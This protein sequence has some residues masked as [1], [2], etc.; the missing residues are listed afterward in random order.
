MDASAVGVEMGD[1]HIALVEL[2]R[3]PGNFFSLEMIAGVA[4]A[5]EPLDGEGRCRAVV[6]A[7]AGKHFCAGADLAADSA[8]ATEDLYA[9]AVRIFRTGLPIVAAVQG[10]AVGGGL[11][12]ALAEA[13]T[14]HEAAEQ[15]RL[16]ATA[17]FAEGVRAMAERRTPR[18]AGS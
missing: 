6:L 4:E 16:R 2:R 3:P 17:D 13:A 15:E 9:A 10:A 11:G 7:A 5:L 8:Y 14:R 12:L 1:D 18:F